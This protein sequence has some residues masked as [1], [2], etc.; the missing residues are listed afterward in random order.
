LSSWLYAEEPSSRPYNDIDLLVEVKRLPAARDVLRDLGFTE[1]SVH[2]DAEAPGHAELWVRGDGAQVDLHR[3]L[4]STR[5][6]EPDT[7][8]LVLMSG[9]ETLVVAGV[10]VDIPGVEVR[11]LHVVLHLDAKDL[12]G[13]QAW[14][15][16]ERAI[17]RVDRASWARAADVAR[18][19]G[20]DDVMGAKL[21][22][23]PA[24]E[25]LADTLALPNYAPLHFAL[26]MAV[27]QDGAT[28]QLY[29]LARMS[30]LRGARAKVHYGWGKLFPSAEFMRYQSALARTGRS[31]LALAYAQ[32]IAWCAARLPRALRE[33]EQLR[34]A[35]RRAH[36]TT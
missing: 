32:R 29:A 35:H 20:I 26:R 36:S 4:H 17:E 14:S 16:L 19:L 15:D 7:L 9:R 33:W 25:A 12:S 21:R 1:R 3:R 24:G 28:P 13:S 11:T 30:S 8:W 2:L 6:V 5:L 23:L 31:G 34:S 27:E 18:E 22:R 10:E